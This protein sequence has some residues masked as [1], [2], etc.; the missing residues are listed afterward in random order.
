VGEVVL[1]GNVLGFYKV[2]RWGVGFLGGWAGGG[3]VLG[4]DVLVCVFG[5]FG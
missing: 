4:M 5:C 2:F 3:F 1:E